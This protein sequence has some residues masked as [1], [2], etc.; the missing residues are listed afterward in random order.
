MRYITNRFDKG[1]IRAV[2]GSIAAT[3][4]CE[5]VINLRLKNGQLRVIGKKKVLKQ[6]VQYDSVY[7]H[8]GVNFENI[9]AVDGSDVKWIKDDSEVLIHSGSGTIAIS[10]INNLL[11][12]NDTGADSLAAYQFIDS[13]YKIYFDKFPDL[14]A[15]SITKTLFQS[16]SSLL[17]LPLENIKLQSTQ[18]ETKAALLGLYNEAIRSDDYRARGWMLLSLNFTLFDGSETK[19]T[20]PVLISLTG[21]RIVNSSEDAI[22]FFT[23][24]ERAATNGEKSAYASVGTYYVSLKFNNI[25][26]YNKYFDLIRAVNIYVTN[27]VSDVDATI[28][29]LSL[30]FNANM[31]DYATP[32]N[33][34]RRKFDKSIFSTQLFYR[35]HS[36]N[37]RDINTEEEYKIRFGDYLP[38]GKTMQVDSSGWI[39]TTGMPFIYNNRLHLYNIKRSFLKSQKLFDAMSNPDTDS[40]PATAYVYIKTASGDKITSGSVNIKLAS[41]SGDEIYAILNDFIAF[42]DSRAYKLVLVYTNSI[43]EQ[44]YVGTLTLIASESYNFSFALK[45]ADL[46]GIC[47]LNESSMTIIESSLVYNENNVIIA[48]EQNNPAYF[49]V[50]NSYRIPGA[51]RELAVMA[52]QISETQTGQ[53]PVF[54]FTDSGIFALEQG[55]GAVLYS[56][57]VPINTDICEIGVRQTRSGIAY[58]ANGKIYILSG[59]VATDISAMLDGE[60]DL[61]IRENESFEKATNNAQLCT[62]I[63]LLSQGRFDEYV[64]DAIILYN[65]VE[66]ELIISNSDYLYSYVYNINSG[67]WSKI[68]E[69][70]TKSSADFA[71]SVTSSTSVDIPASK[72]KAALTLQNLIVSDEVNFTSQARAIFSNTNAVIQPCSVLLK[73]NNEIIAATT[74]QYATP[75]YIV[76]ELLLRNNSNYAC[77]Y[78]DVNHQCVIYSDSASDVLKT[79]SL[80]MSSGTSIADDFEAYSATVTIARKGINE[81]V[82]I[83]L[84]GEIVE[85]T[86]TSALS[87]AA[88]LSELKELIEQIAENFTISI[89]NNSLRIEYLYTGVAGNA[90]NLTVTGSKYCI[91][92]V[93]NFAGGAEASNEIIPTGKSIVDIT[94]EDSD[95]RLIHLQTRPFSLE[96]SGF[97]NVKSALRGL[98]FPSE[99]KIIGVYIFASNNLL[100]WKIVEAGQMN[101]TFSLLKLQ[102]SHS[103]YRYY[104]L[105][106]CGYV[107]SA[108]EITHL[109]CEIIDKFANKLR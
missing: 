9:I 103:S 40:I 84:N 59:R 82:A 65:A 86:I 108:T 43:T 36:I 1:I 34:K 90:N 69:V 71:L 64:R 91:M 29:N 19:M 61:S 105:L 100:E 92:S 20:P 83:N 11:I 77:D 12:I 33:F 55:S 73:L 17:K 21:G 18:K 93:T 10:F 102:R 45:R 89:V 70:F 7:K 106:I 22:N 15:V 87:F 88:F 85:F 79:L 68:S 50:S 14:P 54:I 16:E 94:Q 60:L 25:P 96:S 38:A 57:L 48:S 72:S 80:E 66:N 5:E 42:P 104:S 44:R 107:E 47:K 101:R 58:K 99:D 76:L 95:S 13:A 28:D 2:A 30:S 3:G 46:P 78:T 26:D 23:Y 81:V 75:L 62:S 35:Q 53:F 52:E 74:L 67:S 32:F 27:P 97:K 37:I 6:G 8:K 4:S 98:I 56:N 24:Y 109:D 63:A 41:G 49:N 39:G 31:S 51:V